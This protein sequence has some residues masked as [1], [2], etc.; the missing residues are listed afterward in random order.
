MKIVT[1]SGNG[2]A[3]P[4]LDM[5]EDKLPIEFTKIQNDPDGTFP[6]GI[7]NPLLPENREITS[8]AV[9]KHSADLGIAW[10]GDFDRCFFFN[11]NGEFI[12]SYYLIALLSEQLL[13]YHLV[14][15]LFMIQ[16]WFGILLKKSMGLAVSLR[17]QSLGIHLSKKSCVKIT[18]Y[19]VER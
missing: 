18:Q 8:K 13:N 19:M 17:F 4:I 3:G 10:D 11:S 16:D 9:I 2:C 14:R 12:E 5:L 7:P 6:N 15:A 1:N